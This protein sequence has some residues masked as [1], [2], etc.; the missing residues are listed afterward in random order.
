MD[1]P[2]FSGH[3]SA[4]GAQSSKHWNRKWSAAGNV[5]NPPLPGQ[6]PTPL[7]P[8]CM[9]WTSTAIRSAPRRPCG[10]RCASQ[11]MPPEGGPSS[12]D[13]GPHEN[14]T[15]DQNDRVRYV[16]RPWAPFA[17]GRRVHNWCRIPCKKKRVHCGG[18]SNP[19]QMPRSTGNMDN[20]T[21]MPTH[22]TGFRR[23]QRQ[24]GSRIPLPPAHWTMRPGS[25]S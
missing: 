13:N 9:V 12:C 23:P 6:C 11:R 8:A 7:A 5:E 18:R 16:P 4:R 17:T 21:T 19:T 1:R 20:R 14:D 22:G 2:S 24:D 10:R 25:S 15:S 3:R